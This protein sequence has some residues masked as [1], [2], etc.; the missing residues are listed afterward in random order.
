MNKASEIEYTIKFVRKQSVANL[1][2]IL[3]N[4]KRRIERLKVVQDGRIAESVADEL[5]AVKVVLSG[6]GVPADLL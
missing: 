5:L 1:S 3:R 6:A 2:K 4:Y